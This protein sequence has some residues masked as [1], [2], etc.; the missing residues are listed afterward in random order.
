MPSE[1]LLDTNIVIF[2]FLNH[3]AVRRQEHRKPLRYLPFI[4]ASELLF[5]AKRSG[6]REENLRAYNAFLDRLTILFPNRKTLEL[7]SD[8]RLALWKIGRPIPENDLWQAAI[9]IQQNA[10][11]VT[12]DDH[13]AVVPGLLTEDWTV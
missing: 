12:N 1:Y 3:P 2:L 4:T 5:G 10:I 11:L 9:A 8:L 7:Y 13:F 6:R